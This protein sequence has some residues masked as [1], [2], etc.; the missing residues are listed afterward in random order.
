MINEEE[1][2]K[3]AEPYY[4]HKDIM[5]NMWHI[6]LVKKQLDKILELGGYKVDYD[7]LLTAM[8]FHGFIYSD[9]ERIREWLKSQGCTN[10]ETEKIVKIAWESQR[11]ETPETLEG[12][13]LHDAHVL[14]GGK[15]YLVVKTLITGSVRGQSLKETLNYMEKNVLNT[16]KCFLPETISLCNEM[17]DYTEMFFRELVEGIR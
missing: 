3:F 10:E 13:I 9:E 2:K 16:N 5:H 6:E 17:N 15:T 14:E 11:T 1:V 8:Y 12:K 7:S 4:I